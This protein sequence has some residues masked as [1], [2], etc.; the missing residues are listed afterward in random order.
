V[1]AAVTRVPGASAVLRGGFVVYAT[2]LKA[3]LTDVPTHLLDDRGPVDPEVAAAMAQGACSRTSATWGVATTGV[4]GPDPVGALDPGTV[5]IA[6][7]GPDG[8]T[9]R[10]LQLPGDR[11]RV[12]RLTVA[13]VLDDLRRRLAARESR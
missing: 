13:H 6:V 3:S 10:V 1:A 2:D 8:T 12:R 4:A 7:A 9:T 5:V 11:A